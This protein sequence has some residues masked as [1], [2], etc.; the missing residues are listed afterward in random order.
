MVRDLNQYLT[1][2]LGYFRL[3]AGKTHLQSLDEWLRRKLR[4][5]KLK[6]CK[7]CK[8]IATFLT[9]HGVPAWN[10]WRMAASGKGWWRK[11]KTP[12]AHGA[13][14]IVWFTKLGLINLTQR[15][16]ALQH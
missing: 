13:M 6:H 1:G 9:Q 11:A 10:A 5:V 16:V 4:C 14:T 2:W 7:R 12:Q 15:Y 3:A 8:T